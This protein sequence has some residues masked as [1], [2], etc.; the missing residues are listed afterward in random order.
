MTH[1]KTEGRDESYTF[2][3]W[4][5]SPSTEAAQG[6]PW[7]ARLKADSEILDAIEALATDTRPS[8]RFLVVRDSFRLIDGAPEVFLA[9][10]GGSRC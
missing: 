2:P 1:K 10:C 4:S 3:S 6:L 8:I 5:P 7:L 9:N